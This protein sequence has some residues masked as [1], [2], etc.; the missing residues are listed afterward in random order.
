MNTHHKNTAPCSVRARTALRLQQQHPSECDAQEH[1]MK[2]CHAIVNHP[3]CEPTADGLL[4]HG[5]DL[6]VR[7]KITKPDFVPT[8]LPPGADG[9][10]LLNMKFVWAIVTM[11][12]FGGVSTTIHNQSTTQERIEHERLIKDYVTA[13]SDGDSDNEIIFQQIH[14]LYCIPGLEERRKNI[15]MQVTYSDH[16]TRDIPDSESRGRIKLKV[17]QRGLAVST[18]G[19]HRGYIER[20]SPNGYLERPSVFTDISHVLQ[21]YFKDAMPGKRTVD[22]DAV[23]GDRWTKENNENGSYVTAPNVLTFKAAINVIAMRYRTLLLQ[24]MKDAKME[25][26]L[27]TWLL[28]RPPSALGEFHN[29][30]VLGWPDN[31]GRNSIGGLHQ[32]STIMAI[33]SPIASVN[34]HTDKLLYLLR[35]SSGKDGQQLFPYNNFHICW[36]PDKNINQIKMSFEPF[37]EWHA[38]TSDRKSTPPA[39]ARTP[40]AR[41]P[42]AETV[43]PEPPAAE[44]VAPEPPATE[45]VAPEPP[46]AETVAPRPKFPLWRAQGPPK[47]TKT[48]VRYATLSED[49]RSTQNIHVFDRPIK[50]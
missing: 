20:T 30:P 35:N 44:T 27:E 38:I 43:A 14:D 4:L 46:A 25:G 26:D 42:A 9:K 15:W 5:F 3:H 8:P 37:E 23:S 40:A 48:F 33:F 31:W 11:H 19:S 50:T 32:T 13:I 34:A 47:T 17:F 12:L 36:S 29:M 28:P 1:Y 7:L 24:H 16:K 45:T 10:Y 6:G 39:A 18:D 22:S 2:C 49:L 41:T 21:K